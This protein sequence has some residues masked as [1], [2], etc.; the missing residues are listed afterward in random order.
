[1]FAR[2]LKKL[3]AILLEDINTGEHSIKHTNHDKHFDPG[4]VKENSKGSESPHEGQ[5]YLLIT[6]HAYTQV[7]D[8]NQ[9]RHVLNSSVLARRKNRPIF[10]VV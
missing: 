2:I 1:M 9:V 4:S 10:S 3:L 5:D 8:K 6:E 7:N